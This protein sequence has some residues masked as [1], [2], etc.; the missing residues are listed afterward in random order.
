MHRRAQ[1]IA[2]QEV[3]ELQQDVQCAKRSHAHHSLNDFRLP[4]STLDGGFGG[5]ELAFGFSFRPCLP[6]EQG[7]FVSY[8]HFYCP[9]RTAGPLFSFLTI[10]LPS[11]ERIIKLLDGTC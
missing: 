1:Q 8:F 9:K 2:E 3:P 6:W 10:H 4:Q 5:C 7:T 11:S